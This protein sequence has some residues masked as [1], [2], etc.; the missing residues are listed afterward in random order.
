MTQTELWCQECNIAFRIVLNEDLVS[1]LCL[2]CNN[3]KEKEE[4][5]AL[6]L[7]QC[8]LCNKW[9]NITNLDPLA[10][11]CNE[12]GEYMKKQEYK[13]IAI[14]NFVF[15]IVTKYYTQ[16]KVL[17]AL[18]GGGMGQVY[19][20]VDDRNTRHVLKMPR[21]KKKEYIQR[22]RREAN[23]M[24]EIPLDIPGI[25][26]IEQYGIWKDKP[27]FIM[28]YVDGKHWDEWNKITN[29]NAREIMEMTCKVCERLSIYHKKIVHRDIKPSNILISSKGTPSVI[30]LGIAKRIVEE[31]QQNPTV[32]TE[33]INKP[34]LGTTGYRSPETCKGKKESPS[35][36]IFS[37]GIILYK[38]LTGF[39]PF[40]KDKVDFT[41]MEWKTYSEALETDA[42]PIQERE[43]KIDEN[44]AKI[45]MKCL[46]IQPDKRYSNAEE[47]GKDIQKF[48]QGEKISDYVTFYKYGI[49]WIK[50]H[51]L[52]ALTY[53]LAF[54]FLLS[55]MLGFT[56]YRIQK[57]AQFYSE[58]TNFLKILQQQE[59]EI[60]DQEQE[61]KLDRLAWGKISSC[62]QKMWEKSSLFYREYPADQK[63]KEK[64]IEFTERY[65]CACLFY[66]DFARASVFQ[67]ELKMIC[68][69][70]KKYWDQIF[71]KVEEA[72]CKEIKEIIEKI[73]KNGSSE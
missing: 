13:H 14:P 64:H 49:R 4:E 70:R 65:Y 56:I 34:A 21:F 24:T 28:P 73:Q 33:T 17:G 66:D 7:W 38:F 3:K 6:G 40:F 27:F 30:D 57:F 19:L 1:T 5:S 44:I 11:C 41:T 29:P 59:K 16:G 20:F 47:L 35:T 50:R 53:F 69:E 48:L 45:C 2:K 15:Q 55:L 72:R 52:K 51:K 36:D 12:C 54:S 68:P 43:N 25:V 39:H 60:K 37:L 32:V 62:Y 42:I 71:Q 18:E 22:F 63:S 9:I 46:E 8:N 23:L 10:V 31:R 61:D 58:R 26:G 67:N